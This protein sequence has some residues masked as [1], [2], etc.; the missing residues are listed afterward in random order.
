MA[1]SFQ[2]SQDVIEYF[3][4]AEKLIDSKEIPDEDVEDFISKVYDQVDGI[5]IRLCH[6]HDTSR[7]LEK[8][9][10]QS[11]EFQLRVFLER[12]SGNYLLM[13][14]NRFASHVLQAILATITF[15]EEALVND[16]GELGTSESLVLRLV[17]E[18]EPELQSL[19]VDNFG[20]HVLRT[21][22]GCLKGEIV[23]NR[24]K[25]SK[26][27]AES[28]Q[29]SDQV[30]KRNVPAS[31]LLKLQ[32][33][34]DSL[35]VDFKRWA[36]DVTASP[37]LQVLINNLPEK[38][39]IYAKLFDIFDQSSLLSTA[40]HSTGSHFL[41]CFVKNA[42]EFQKIFNLLRGNLC[43]LSLDSKGN[44]VVQQLIMGCQ[45]S[46]QLSLI[47]EELSGVLPLLVQRGK[48]GI[49][50]KIVKS[51]CAMNDCFETS[52][53]AVFSA[54][55]VKTNSDKK[56]IVSLILHQNISGSTEK[57]P[58]PSVLGALILDHVMKFP[59]N[60]I[61][62]FI[63]SFLNTP[64]E[65]IKAFGTDPSGSRAIE[66]FMKG[67]SPDGAKRKFVLKMIDLVPD[68]AMDRFGSHIVDSFWSASDTQ[69]RE[70]LAAQLFLKKREIQ[71]TF[72]GNMVLKNCKIDEYEKSQEDWIEKEESK[73]HKK[74]IF[75]EIL[76]EDGAYAKEIEQLGYKKKKKEK[77]RTESDEIDVLFKSASNKEVQLKRNLTE[78]DPRMNNELD[79][80]LDQVLPKKKKKSK[81]EK[82][83]N[84]S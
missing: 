7:V 36:L 14:R 43:D 40:K 71:S 5:E 16:Q 13:F 19:F 49:L 22:F 57:S 77:Q 82:S 10:K 6:H 66:S 20:S 23:S 69:L 2:L 28:F 18:I 63:S 73:R 1:N 62:D 67:T 12:F 41:E 29:K 54:Y 31:F 53:K 76:E 75:K 25:S 21:L 11:N 38:S 33:L 74:E 50:E 39:K 30:V 55:H 52:L 51:A 80:V 15:E 46:P 79:K 83:K 8:V 60:L 70:T 37:T 17:E 81:K 9:V 58:K 45:S 84:I 68:F 59:H 64:F 56:N 24:S 26:K 72:F 42:P 3:R 48:V 32:S 35:D 47:I 4:Q 61:N 65:V 78:E 44:F 27:Y 34:G